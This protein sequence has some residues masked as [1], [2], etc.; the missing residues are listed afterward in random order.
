MPWGSAGQSAAGR[1]LNW[2]PL[3][4]VLQERLYI[5]SQGAVTQQLDFFNG[6]CLYTFLSNVVASHAV[7]NPSPSFYCPCWEKPPWWGGRRGKNTEPSDFHTKRP[8]SQTTHVDFKLKIILKHRA[9]FIAD[10][11]CLMQFLEFLCPWIYDV[12]YTFH[13]L[14]ALFP[15]VKEGMIT[16]FVPKW[17]L[18]C[19]KL[20]RASKCTTAWK[21]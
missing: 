16:R 3:S 8:L 5:R 18:F 14:T 17:N 15:H 4:S 10:L 19:L 11:L 1:C 20:C 9:S 13:I 12:L 2:F 6:V 7:K 21:M